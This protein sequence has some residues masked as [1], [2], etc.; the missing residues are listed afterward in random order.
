MLAPITSAS[1]IGVWTMPLAAKD[2]T[3]STID[4]LEWT[5]QV[6]SAPISTAITYS[7]CMPSRALRNGWE[8]RSGSTPDD[9]SRSDSSIRP[10]PIAT[11][12]RWRALSDWPD[13]KEITPIATINGDSQERS[14]ERTCEVSV[15]P[16]LAPSMTAMAIDR[17]INPR[18]AK[19]ATSSAVAVLDC[20][21]AVR[22]TPP[23]KAANLFFEQAP[24]TRR[25]VAPNARVRPVRTMRTPHSRSATAPITL[26]I[27][28]T[29]SM[30]PS[31]YASRAD[32]QSF[33]TVP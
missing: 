7:S 3:S 12:P 4:R 28:V 18:P 10:R 22:A 15:V 33:L 5:A 8:V 25:K 29:P 30:T 24:I 13:R 11:R 1:A 26:R 6:A 20:R 9:S 19:E 27:V 16:I 31:P 17:V 21:I 23:P 2:I 14:N 32:D